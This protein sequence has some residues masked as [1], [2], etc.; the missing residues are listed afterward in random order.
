MTGEQPA[1][2]K[3][4]LIRALISSK[5]ILTNQTW[6][7]MPVI[8]PLEAEAGGLLRAQGQLGLHSET[9]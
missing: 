9:T 6:W 3:S 7:F 1:F 2:F 4:P 5:N 8:L